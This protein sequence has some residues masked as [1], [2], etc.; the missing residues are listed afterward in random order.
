MEPD[1]SAQIKATAIRSDGSREDI[2]AATRWATTDSRVLHVE[3]G[4]LVTARGRGEA[5]IIAHYE[6]SSTASARVL[7][8]PAGTFRLDGVISDSGQG[9]EGAHV[10]VIKGTGAGLRATSNWSG[11]YALYGVA[12]NVK[13][14][15]RKGGYLNQRHD[16]PVIEHRSLNVEMALEQA[17]RDL[18]G[19]YSLVIEPGACG[20]GGSLPDTISRRT[21]QATVEQDGPRLHVE[22]SGAEFIVTNGKGDNF[23]GLLEGNRKV[24]FLIAGS[25]AYYYYNDPAYR[26]DIS[27]RVSPS[28]AFLVGGSVTAVADEAG[29][30][31]SL[32][33]WLVLVDDVAPPF[34]GTSAYCWSSAHRF[35]MRRS[36]L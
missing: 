10:E 32:D 3:A 4:G 34:V 2:T 30:V 23:T 8:L 7:V 1:A 36:V 19:A 5:D 33:G 16:L 29:I 20:F 14:H 26:F 11:A 6:V 25:W 21:Y 17:R 12:G 24:K 22:L 28:S 9:L 18:S 13:V 15:V 31:G 35:T 27:E